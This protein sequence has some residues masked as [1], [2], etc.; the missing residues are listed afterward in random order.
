MQ[1]KTIG[2][3]S[4]KKYKCTRCGHESL[5]G[6]N[7]WG[8][9][10]PICVKCGWKNPMCPQSEHACLEEI[11]EGFGTPPEWEFITLGDIIHKGE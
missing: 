9:I 5:Q 1:T 10:Y 2:K 3:Y 8:K 7:H 6:T 4:Q 11:P